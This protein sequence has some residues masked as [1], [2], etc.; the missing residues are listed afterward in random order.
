MRSEEFPQSKYIRIEPYD[1]GEVKPKEQT[2]DVIN[3]RHGD[4]LCAISYHT[5]WRQWIVEFEG[6]IIFNKDCLE[7]L[8]K[9]LDM[10][11]DKGGK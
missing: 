7:T 10:L 9:T 8:I 11:N 2:Y 6:N 5:P 4:I 1:M 3:K